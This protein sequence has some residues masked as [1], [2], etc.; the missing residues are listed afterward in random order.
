LPLFDLAGRVGHL[1]HRLGFTGPTP[2]EVAEVFPDLSPARRQEL[3][4]AIAGRRFA[5]ALLRR[6]MQQLGVEAFA[7][8]VRCEGEER[9]L[10]LTRR[11]HPVA[12]VPWHSGPLHAITPAL[13]KLGVPALIVRHEP[14]FPAARGIEYVYAGIHENAPVRVL[15][16]AVEWLRK[17]GAVVMPTGVPTPPFEPPPGPFRFL[18]RAVHLIRGPAVL[19]RLGGVELIPVM[20]RWVGREIVVA[21]AAPIPRRETVPGR[22]AQAS[23]ERE[24][25]TALAAWWEQYIR[26]H[27]EELWILSLRAI[28]RSPYAAS[29]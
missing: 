18:G 19:A 16:R 14:Q 27:P 24:V 9:L 3:A 15:K 22:G 6:V 21:F 8:R 10:D 29:S 7:H 25:L 20:P 17:G 1:T 4:R 12:L 11:G 13:V 2:H 23:F 26:E 28:A 5:N